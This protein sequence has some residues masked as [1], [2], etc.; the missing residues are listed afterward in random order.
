MKLFSKISFQPELEEV[1][2][3]NNL[4]GKD[5]ALPKPTLIYLFHDPL[6]NIVIYYKKYLFGLPS[7]EF[8]KV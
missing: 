3:L 1:L 7:C 2:T 8:L 5:R 6:C 4:I